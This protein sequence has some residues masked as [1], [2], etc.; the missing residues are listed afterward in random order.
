MT[1]NG[2]QNKA[3]LVRLSVS[4]WTA[5]RYDRKVSDQAAADFAA[6]NDAGR[7]NKMLVAQDA[8]SRMTKIVSEVR[9]WHY[10]HTLPWQDDGQR[11]LT[12]TYYLD[13]TRDRKSVV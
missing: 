2:I 3:M 12:A 7:Y 4:M 1:V 5:R 6:K 13:Y 9:D 8:I 11:I 10:T